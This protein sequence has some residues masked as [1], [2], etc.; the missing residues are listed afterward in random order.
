MLEL[1]KTAAQATFVIQALLFPILIVVSL[2]AIYWLLTNKKRNLIRKQAYVVNNAYSSQREV[3][4]P[5]KCTNCGSILII[6]EKKHSCMSCGSTQD[7]PLHYLAI[8]KHRKDID[9]KI[10]KAYNYW[11]KTNK[12][13]SP[14]NRGILLILFLWFIAVFLIL[15]ITEDKSAWL[16][17]DKNL[18]YSFL[19]TFGAGS[20]AT[21]FFWA[22]NFLVMRSLLGPKLRNHLPVA[23]SE[24]NSGKSEVA[25]CH[26]CAAPI[27]FSPKS[28]GVVCPYCG[29]E[30]YR[31]NFSWKVYQSVTYDRTAAGF[32]LIEAMEKFKEVQED[33]IS[34]GL[35]LPIIFV[36]LPGLAVFIFYLIPNVIKNGIEFLF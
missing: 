10:A 6:N 29:T 8:F 23:T 32:S 31:V 12:I 18:Y 27:Y 7:I 3:L 11:K 21:L 35:I 1:L 9:A 30:T 15:I 16:R 26:Q 14:V 22:L 4:A 34:S 36:V 28:V 33:A 19:Q 20:I 24:L 17:T 13:T 25:A 2:Y 5:L